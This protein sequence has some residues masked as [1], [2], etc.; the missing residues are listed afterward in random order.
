M[1]ELGL[2]LKRLGH[3]VVAV[4]R[5]FTPGSDLA[6]AFARAFEVRSVAAPPPPPRGPLAPERH[7]W[8]AMRA[9][10]AL[11]PAVDAVNAHEFPA[12]RAG[13]MAAGRLGVPFV[14]TR[15]DETLFERAVI[16]DETT[17]APRDG[18]ERAIHGLVGLA[19]LAD[20]RRAAAVVVLDRR[21]ARMVRRAYRRGARII[22]S[23]PARAF[24]DAPDRG[25]AR[26]RLGVAPGAFLVL[27][28]GVLF[29]YRRLED[30]V[31]AV[32]LDGDPATRLLLVGSD[33]AAPA[34]ADALEARI[35]ERGLA[36]RAEL[37]RTSVTD[38][39]LREAY[40]A[41][42]AFVFPNL[43]QT[44]GLAPLEALASGTPV[45]VSRGAGV[46]EVLEGHPGVTV[47]DP[48]APAQLARALAEL[49]ADPD[50]RAA[51]APTRAWIADA[52]SN[53]R[54]AADMAALLAEVG[55]R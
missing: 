54:Y 50:R 22:R 47:V 55:A 38:A 49:R 30:L 28:F 32:A 5:D 14:W 6:D 44:W 1:L 7:T 10:A 27:A 39:E 45:V 34:Y 42:D 43:R 24:F 33:H 31:D 16:P 23:G 35:A 17:I 46:H 29:P 40:A 12:L 3:E 48:C 21:N 2:G 9:T 4:C 8:A 25:A 13:R 37:R 26:A 53:D 41:A 19:D 11:V 20:A 15:N 51:L 36:G 52:L 18:R